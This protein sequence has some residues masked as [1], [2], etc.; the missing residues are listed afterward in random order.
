MSVIDVCKRGDE[1]ALRK[2]LEAGCDIEE[3]DNFGFTGFIWACR[4]GRK[5]IVAILLETDCKINTQNN[6]GNT[7]LIWACSNGHKDIVAMLLKIGCDINKQNICESTAFLC[8]CGNGH[9]EIIIKLVEH[10]CEINIPQKYKEK[11]KEEI[12]KG[13]QLKRLR[14]RL[15][16]IC[17]EFVKK[18]INK[19][20]NKICILP[21][22]IRKYFRYVLKN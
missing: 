5:D 19:F 8:A 1:N 20:S 7:G 14:M 9:K 17:I 15:F 10:G 21:F 22:D 18:N 13:L 2:L 4:Y 11:Y 6:I 3:R 16:D 12:N